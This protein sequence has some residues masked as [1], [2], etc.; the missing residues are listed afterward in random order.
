MFQTFDLESLGQV[1]I[2]SDAVWLQTATSIKVIAR[3]CYACS[4]HF[5]DIKI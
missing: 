2:R 3:I 5:G 1:H 4:R